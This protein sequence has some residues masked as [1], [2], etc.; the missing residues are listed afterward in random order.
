[1]TAAQDSHSRQ[2]LPYEYECLT[3]SMHNF[4][5]LLPRTVAD[6]YGHGVLADERQLYSRLI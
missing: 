1:M 3:Y 2:K 6:R 4:E 5:R